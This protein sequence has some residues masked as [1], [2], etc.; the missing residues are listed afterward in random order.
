MACG[1][2]FSQSIENEYTLTSHNYKGDIKPPHNKSQD[3]QEHIHTN[4]DTETHTH[5]HRPILCRIETLYGKMVVSLSEK[6]IFIARSKG[7]ISFNR[8]IRK[9]DVFVEDQN[10]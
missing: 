8:K 2:L 9:K 4:T 6:D 5:T 1:S 7:Q 10:G 3:T